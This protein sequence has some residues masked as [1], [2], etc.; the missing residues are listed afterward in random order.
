MTT[1][2]QLVVF[3]VDEEHYALNLACVERIVRAAEITHVPDASPLVLG[4]INVEGRIIPVV[5]TRKRLGLP[6]R[7]IELSDLFLIV[8][9]KG[10]EIAL[11]ADQVMPVMEVSEEQ[12]SAS[13]KAV[14]TN[15]FVD[16]VAKV[17]SGMIMILSQEKTLALDN[18]YLRTIL[19][20]MYLKIGETRKQN[21]G[22][23]HCTVQ[24]IQSG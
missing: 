8:H 17:D 6:E 4:V 11:V 3:T 12:L 23:K 15:G 20:E 21:D 18:Y 7:E 5:N 16:S 19:H 14:S 10:R 1:S 13:E 24:S 22:R 9:E 2:K